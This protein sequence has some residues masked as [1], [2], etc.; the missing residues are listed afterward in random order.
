MKQWA[1][2]LLFVLCFLLAAGLTGSK[3]NSPLD[4]LG[5]SA[6][7]AAEG[8]TLNPTDCTLFLGETKKLTALYAAEGSSKIALEGGRCVWST[9][10]SAV[11]L[12]DAD[13]FV[14]AVGIGTAVV[15]ANSGPLSAGCTI[16][17]R[18]RVYGAHELSEGLFQ[19]TE[20]GFEPILPGRWSTSR[21]IKY[22]FAEDCS[23]EAFL[24]L[25]PDGRLYLKTSGSVT[26]CT[27]LPLEKTG[28]TFNVE[29]YQ[30]SLG[31]EAH[32]FSL[33][34]VANLPAGKRKVSP[35]S[36][37]GVSP[38]AFLSEHALYL[39]TGGSILLG[40]FAPEDTL[41]VGYYDNAVYRE[42]TFSADIWA[43]QPRE[44]GASPPLAI[45]PVQTGTAYT[46]LPFS[47]L[48]AGFYKLDILV[49]KGMTYD[50]YY[51]N[52]LN[53]LCVLVE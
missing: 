9:T 15:Q 21:S 45:R 34:P 24:T 28:Y 23:G 27:L 25:P 20:D 3:E 13:G 47:N 50:Q 43:A 8:L 41:S 32:L 29:Y 39:G 7:S 42:E 52:L 40:D 22:I 12:V 1:R 4:F 33:F 30:T 26:E 16:T 2:V 49:K 31:I 17:V 19:R 18:E 6:G 11:A 37:N 5:S 38:E 36:L 48:R 10:D 14:T 35:A 53:S 46:V 44:T 51:K